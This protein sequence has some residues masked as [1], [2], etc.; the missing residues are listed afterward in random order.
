MQLI[1]LA[2]LLPGSH[3]LFLAL[4]SGDTFGTICGFYTQTVLL[5]VVETVYKT[6]CSDCLNN[7]RADRNTVHQTCQDTMT[8]VCKE[9]RMRRAWDTIC[10]KDPRKYCT[11]STNKRRSLSGGCQT[12]KKEPV[13][14]ERMVPTEVRKKT[15]GVGGPG[16]PVH[17]GRGLDRKE[18]TV[19]I[20]RQRKRNT[21]L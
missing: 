4:G 3:G 16:G 21:Y 20:R 10:N 1:I 9:V 2:H 15:C 19:A 7:N 14:V 17:D 12:C 6:V 8:R 18:Y 11:G 13:E 5:P